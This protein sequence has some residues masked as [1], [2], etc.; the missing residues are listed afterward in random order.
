MN[1]YILSLRTAR[2]CDWYKNINIILILSVTI[3]VA[4]DMFQEDLHACYCLIQDEDYCSQ[5]IVICTKMSI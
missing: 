2:M 4:G 1:N 5:S 3:K